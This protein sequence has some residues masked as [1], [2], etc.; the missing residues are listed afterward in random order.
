VIRRPRSWDVLRWGLL[1][2]SPSLADEGKRTGRYAG[3]GWAP[4][5]PRFSVGCT[6]D[7]REVGTPGG[8]GEMNNR[9]FNSRRWRRR[10]QIQ[11]PNR[12]VS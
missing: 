8:D 4:L 7:R 2:M 5:R 3:T 10:K 9:L 11:A 12:A 6:G 1:R